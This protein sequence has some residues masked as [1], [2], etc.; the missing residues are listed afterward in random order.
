M[1]LAP[2]PTTPGSGPS[3]AHTHPQPAGHNP[4]QSLVSSSCCTFVTIHTDK[5]ANQ[6]IDSHRYT[7]GRNNE[8]SDGSNKPENDTRT[9]TMAAGGDQHPVMGEKVLNDAT[10]ARIVSS[11]LASRLMTGGSSRVCFR[12]TPSS[13][14]FIDHALFQKATT[15]IPRSVE[16]E[17]KYLETSFKTLKV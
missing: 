4:R 5:Q 6:K 11:S 13:T 14:S 17:S 10:I 2:L 3:V 12:P 16:S 8:K 1:D 9:K 15:R 7:K